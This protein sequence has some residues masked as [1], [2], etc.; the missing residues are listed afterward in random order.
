MNSKERLIN[1]QNRHNIFYLMQPSKKE[2]LAEEEKYPNVG[3][4]NRHLLC[5]PSGFMPYKAFWKSQIKTKKNSKQ[6]IE[7]TKQ[8]Y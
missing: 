6:R 2:D 1:Q 7:A 3:L 5:A 8:R 4:A